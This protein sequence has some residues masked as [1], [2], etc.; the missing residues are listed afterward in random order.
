MNQEHHLPIFHL[1]DSHFDF[2]DLAPTDVPSSF[3]EFSRQNRLSP[4]AIAPDPPNLP[5]DNILVNHAASKDSQTAPTIRAR[6]K[7]MVTAV[8]FRL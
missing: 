6:A 4:T 2:R 8:E 3:L 5:T 1:P 7:M